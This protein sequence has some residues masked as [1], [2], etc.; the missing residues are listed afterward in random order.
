MELKGT[1]FYIHL[2]NQPPRVRR[3]IEGILSSRGAYICTI[4]CQDV[5]HLLTDQDNLAVKGY[6]MSKANCL[7]TN[8]RSMR[9]VEECCQQ[10]NTINM[11]NLS[12]NATAEKLEFTTVALSDIFS[13]NDLRRIRVSD[14][15]GHT[16]NL[17]I[18]NL[19]RF[20]DN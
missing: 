14:P 3:N 1:R 16:K 19:L 6:P 17:F 18:E 12:L 15:D 9:M 13:R 2:K 10:N 7:P 4:L 8:T 20:L 11:L 5:T